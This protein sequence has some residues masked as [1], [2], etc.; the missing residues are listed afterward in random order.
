MLLL[1]GST[2]AKEEEAGSTA[3]EEEKTRCIFCRDPCP[4]L[5]PLENAYE[6]PESGI[7]E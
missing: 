7:A 5:L 1:T 4:H 2:A 3:A 6:P